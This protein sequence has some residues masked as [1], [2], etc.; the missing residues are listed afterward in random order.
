MI[1]DRVTITGIDD[2]TDVKHLAD[3]TEEFPFV[4]WG[5]LVSATQFG[6]G[7]R[8]PSRSKI[9]YFCREI[10]KDRLS[11]H[12]CGGWIRSM[13]LGTNPLSK[14]LHEGFGRIQLN[15]HGIDYACDPEFLI[16]ALL[17]FGQSQI[18]FQVDGRR[19][20][21]YLDYVKKFDSESKV[22]AVPLFDTSGGA[23]V[24]PKEWPIADIHCFPYYGYAGGLGPDNLAQQIPLIA[25]AAGDCRIWIDMETK[26]RT[27]DDRK[28]DLDK[29]RQC[30]KI[31]R[32]FVT[33]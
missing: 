17:E 31:A 9:V 19:G 18:I 27:P 22:N 28:L 1:L 24:I 23:G 16:K 8:F 10:P 12:I 5:V 7:A 33:K 26:V 11:M 30:L 3:L 21:K 14:N 29:V 32:P 6:V 13:L 25:Q 2:S 20:C 4:E 15:F